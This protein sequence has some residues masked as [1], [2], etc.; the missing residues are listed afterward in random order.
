V[1]ARFDE[2]LPDLPLLLAKKRVQLIGLIGR[3]DLK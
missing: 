2:L 3:L 1:D